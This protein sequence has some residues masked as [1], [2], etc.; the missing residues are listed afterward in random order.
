MLDNVNMN[1]NEIKHNCI[2]RGSIF[3][4][5]VQVI[6]ITDVGCNHPP[7]A[8]SGAILGEWRVA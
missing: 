6:L 2:V 7:L 8:W 3:P 1:R 4:E 5:P